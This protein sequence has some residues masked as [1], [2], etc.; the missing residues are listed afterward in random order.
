MVDVEI[1]KNVERK[2]S[3]TKNIENIISKDLIHYGRAVNIREI[4][5]IRTVPQETRESR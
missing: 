3:S 4:P 5:K 2:T 1:K